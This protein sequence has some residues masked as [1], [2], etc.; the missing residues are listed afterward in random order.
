[1]KTVRRGEVWSCEAGRGGPLGAV[2]L[3]CP[4]KSRPAPQERKEHF[5]LGVAA[6]ACACSSVRLRLEERVQELEES[7]VTRTVSGALGWGPRAAVGA[8]SSRMVRAVGKQGQRE[9]LEC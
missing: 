6:L 7:P 3:L 2:L 5:R 1:M 9:I 8:A 4:Q